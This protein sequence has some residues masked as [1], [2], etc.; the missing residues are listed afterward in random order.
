MKRQLLVP[1]LALPLI[2][3]AQTVLYNDDFESYTAGALIA[4]TDTINWSTWSNDPGGTEDAPISTAHAQSGVNSIAVVADTVIGGP[5]DLLLKLGD[6][7]TGIYALSF[8]MYIPSGMGGY[9]NLQHQ[10]DAAPPQYAI[11]VTFLANGN[12]RVDAGDTLTI[13]TYPH[14]A[15]FT[16]SMYFDLGAITAQLNVANNYPYN[17]A[18]NT[19]NNVTTLVNKIGAIDFFA[20]GGLVDLGEYYVDNVEFVDNTNIGIGELGSDVLTFGPNPVNDV[21]T[22]SLAGSSGSRVE[23][24]D[25][26]G[27]LV[28]S[29]TFPV[30]NT[31][32]VD[33]SGLGGGVYTMRI[34]NG[35]QVITRKVVKN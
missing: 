24:L 18:S 34:S 23:L 10:E 8:G 22:I 21:L 2:T 33:M 9:F 6:R 3:M 27:K 25:A 20:Y 26:A 29:V 31:L 14:D 5:V 32:P 1:L 17:W 16:V 19:S 13:G 15:W 7:T 12:V 30:G 35:D 4:E 11:D 28:S